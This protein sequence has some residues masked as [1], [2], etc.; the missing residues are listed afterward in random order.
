MRNRA[1]R[2]NRGDRANNFREKKR[3]V[4]SWKHTSLRILK[5]KDI[6]LFCCAADAV[7]GVFS[8]AGAFIFAAGG[9][10]IVAEG[11]N[12]TVEVHCVGL[13]D[14]VTAVVNIHIVV[15]LAEHILPSEAKCEVIVFEKRFLYGC[16]E[17]PVVVCEFD[18]GE[19]RLAVKLRV[20]FDLPAVREA[21]GVVGV[22]HP[23][24][25]AKRALAVV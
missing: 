12:H 24:R 13:V 5:R 7:A 25:F 22:E 20:K 14:A 16:F 17:R 19:V 15:S 10:E 4:C 11:E 6:V 23:H 1:N 3:G 18:I 8:G 2:A 9:V 21:E